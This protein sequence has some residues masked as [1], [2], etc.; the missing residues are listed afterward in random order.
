MDVLNAHFCSSRTLQLAELTIVAAWRLKR[1][2]SVSSLAMTNRRDCRA[3][4]LHALMATGN[5][6]AVIIYY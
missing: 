6:N 1:R 5:D 3:V 2:R 4:V